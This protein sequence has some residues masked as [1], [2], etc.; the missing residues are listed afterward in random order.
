MRSTTFKII[1][2]SHNEGWCTC[3]VCKVNV[4]HYNQGWEQIL[5]TLQGYLRYKFYQYNHYIPIL[6]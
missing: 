6:Y 4:V 3:F 2:L 1:N 5:L